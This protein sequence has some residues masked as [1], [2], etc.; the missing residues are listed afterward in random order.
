EELVKA[1]DI[2]A[3]KLHT[4]RSAFTR[5]ALR[6]A[7]AHMQTIA[8]EERHRQGYKRYPV[9]GNEFSVWENEQVWGDR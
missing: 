3:K 5:R 1:V 9:R 4:T 7:L 6:D 2:A 8:Q